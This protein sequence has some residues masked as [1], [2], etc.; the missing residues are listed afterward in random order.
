M[1]KAVLIDIDNTLL[2]FNKCATFAIKS[3]F[4]DFNIEFSD[5]IFPVFK[6]INDKLWLQV[7][8]KTLTKPE[9]HKIRWKLIFN[10]LGIE[11]D[12]VEFEKV[13]V[14]YVHESHIPVDGALDLLQ[15]L[16]AKYSVYAASNASL[17][18]Q[19][20]RLTKANMI[21]YVKDI[22]VSDEIGFPKPSGE[23]FDICLSRIAP[24]KKEELV[25][26][27]DSLTADID[28]GTKYGI[29]T[30]WFNHDKEE[31]PADLKADYIV[32]SLSDIKNIF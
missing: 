21:K 10:E 26:I 18:Q 7:E 22:F 6:E 9:L 32:D 3:G 11:K 24:L 16:S 31:V 14:N 25:M 29:A 15:Y 17:K 8:Q 5:S 13:F 1:I 27:G 28:G 2:D 4:E 30:C 23:F 19:I 12:G 20:N